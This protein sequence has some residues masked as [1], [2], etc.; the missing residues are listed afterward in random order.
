MQHT[1]VGQLE[2]KELQTLASYRKAATDM[3]QQV[4]QLEVQKAR[5]L[6]QMGDVEERAQKIMNEAKTRLGVEASAQCFITQDGKVM[7]V[8]QTPVAPH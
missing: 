5:L 1:E 2:E 6:G 7:V 4:G 8:D 3:I